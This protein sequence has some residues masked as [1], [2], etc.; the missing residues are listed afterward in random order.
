LFQF[1]PYRGTQP[2]VPAG[3]PI[4]V[5]LNL[6]ELVELSKIFQAIIYKLPDAGDGALAYFTDALGG[7]AAG[8]VQELFGAAGDGAEPAEIADDATA[9]SLAEFL[10]DPVLRGPADAG[11]VEAREYP[12]I[13][14]ASCA[15]LR[16]DA[17]GDG[18]YGVSAVHQIVQRLDIFGIALPFTGVFL[19]FQFIP[20]GFTGD[21]ELGGQDSHLFFATRITYGYAAFA[22]GHYDFFEILD[23]VQDFRQGF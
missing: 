17:A 19:H 18:H 22:T 12:E 11:G 14:I 2:A 1:L 23:G 8:P 20:G 21:A 7:A 3:R 10:P 9:A 6:G 4:F 16:P 15:I 5:E 13:G